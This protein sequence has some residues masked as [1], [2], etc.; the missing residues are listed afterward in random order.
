MRGG[1]WHTCPVITLA[2]TPIGN[3]SDASA[4]LRELLET[5]D[6]IAAEDTRKLRGLLSR[7]EVSTAAEIV[8]YHEHN[9]A[10][11]TGDLLA[12]ARAGR[13]VLVV[14]DA[15]MPGISD[16]GYRIVREAA[17]AGLEVTVAPG[18]SAALAAIAL[19]G[20][21]TDRFCFEGFLPRKP[22]ARA[23]ALGALASEVRTM[24]F[25]EAP[26]RVAA[27]LEAMA[28]AFGSDRSA[29]MCRELTKTYEEVTRGSLADLLARA[30]R[31]VKGE[32]VVVV[33]G[34]ESLVPELPELVEAVRERMG[35]GERM[36]EAVSSVARDT[37]ARRRALYEAVL[38]G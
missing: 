20:L 25:Y 11:R 22:G 7:L 32:I 21:P 10:S 24:V 36:A 18:P 14:S 23:A 34:K 6:V 37:G 9:E 1:A 29:A 19:S 31:G 13:N 2:A 28:D 15:G 27:T 16:P 30:E 26:H 4:R 38:R 33:A 35:A 3:A 5:S 12:H 8:A 17:A